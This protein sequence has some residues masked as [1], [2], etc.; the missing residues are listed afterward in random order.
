MKALSYITTNKIKTKVAGYTRQVAASIASGLS[1][2][3]EDFCS[4]N[5]KFY[6]SKKDV[7]LHKK[8]RI[9]DSGH[10]TFLKILNT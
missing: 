4:A 7:E 8:K 6:K 2:E 9:L 10:K 5:R 1:S 3:L